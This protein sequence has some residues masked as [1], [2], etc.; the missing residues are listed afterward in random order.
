MKESLEDFS[1]TKEQF[2]QLILIQ[3]LVLLYL[4]AWRVT[5]F[6]GDFSKNFYIFIN[7]RVEQRSNIKSLDK[8][9]TFPPLAKHLDP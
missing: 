2:S 1:L 5:S 9:K 3:K 6:F 7:L 4:V 8:L